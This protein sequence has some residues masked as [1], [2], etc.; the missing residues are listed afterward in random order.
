MAKTRSIAQRMKD[1]TRDL[2]T[3][4]GYMAAGKAAPKIGGVRAPKPVGKG[5]PKPK[6]K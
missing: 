4:E 3:A 6:R 1:R 2:D 5:K